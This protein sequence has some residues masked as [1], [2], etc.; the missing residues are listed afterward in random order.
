MLILATAS[1]NNPN[2]RTTA[3][4][5]TT[6]KT[7]DELDRCLSNLGVPYY[8][9]KLGVKLEKNEFVELLEALRNIDVN[10]ILEAEAAKF[11]KKKYN[12]ELDCILD[13]VIQIG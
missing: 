2:G 8:V 13:H 3:A 7:K 1:K 4:R 11:C 9:Y 6:F 10:M 12:N 5:I